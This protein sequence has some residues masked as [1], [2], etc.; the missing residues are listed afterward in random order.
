M[1]A[2]PSSEEARLRDERN[3][4]SAEIGRRRAAGLPPDDL[5]DRHRAVSAQ[6]DALRAEGDGPTGG[7]AAAREGLTTE[8]ETSSEAFSAL[9][10]EWRDLL[11]DSRAD[12]PFLRWEWLYSWWEVFGGGKQLRLVTVRGRPDGRLLALAP[13]MLGVGGQSRVLGFIGT[14]EVA[15]GDYWSIILRAGHERE[16]LTAVWQALSLRQS[17][18]DGVFLRDVWTADPT[19]LALV[20]CAAES[21]WDALIETRRQSVLG[22]LGADFAQFIGSVPDAFRRNQLRAT[23]EYLA[24][25]GEGTTYAVAAGESDVER[26]LEAIARFSCTRQAT[27]GGRSAWQDRRFG[28][29]MREACERLRGAGALVVDTLQRGGDVTAGVV[30]FRQGGR[31]C[32]Y[33][34]GFDPAAPPPAPLHHLFARRIQAC[35][36]GGERVFDFLAGTHE[37]KT[38]YFSGRRPVGHLHLLPHT[39]RSRRRIGGMMLAQGI[40]AQARQ[41][42]ERRSPR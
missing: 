14:G 35:I 32:C 1:S 11:D 15:E 22:P 34:I 42:L 24:R 39:H 38:Q 23:D 41:W 20:A 10:D 7:A 17:E 21:G 3:A 36:D 8:V 26:A 9:R 37:Y 31:Y 33:Q 13:M 6:L 27:K 2:E 40:R 18:H 4:I 12:T 16:A 19:L 28:T 30:G 5:I 29:F 25:H